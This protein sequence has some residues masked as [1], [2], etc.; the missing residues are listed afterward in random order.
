MAQKLYEVS[1]QK[2]LEH[3]DRN[4]K[5]PCISNVA[6]INIPSAP[7]ECW[8]SEAYWISGK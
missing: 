6:I 2:E 4:F 7:I 5:N 8:H 3:C 1:G